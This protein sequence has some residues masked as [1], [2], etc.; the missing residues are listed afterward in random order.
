MLTTV[1]FKD[2]SHIVMVKHNNTYV[3]NRNPDGKWAVIS[4]PKNCYM[5]ENMEY[6]VLDE[7]EAYN[8]YKE[9]MASFGYR[10]FPVSEQ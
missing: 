7:D 9:R 8:Y 4:L 10:R 2:K 5:L 6:T 3:M 1:E